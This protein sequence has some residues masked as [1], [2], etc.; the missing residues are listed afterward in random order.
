MPAGLVQLG[1]LLRQE[2]LIA[3]SSTPGG[4]SGAELHQQLAPLNAPDLA[5]FFSTGHA[6]YSDYLTLE[7]QP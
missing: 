6:V 5:S 1:E 3:M 7:P 4:S 2:P